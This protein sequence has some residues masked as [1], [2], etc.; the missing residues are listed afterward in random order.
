MKRVFLCHFILKI[1]I[2]PRQAREKHRE[3]TQKE[4][5]FLIAHVPEY[6]TE[7]LDVFSF[8]LSASEMA[9]ISAI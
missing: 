2:L 4:T 1:I 3:T 5:C 7:D 6:I 8:T 9:R